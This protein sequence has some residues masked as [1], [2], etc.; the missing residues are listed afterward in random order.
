MD[1]DGEGARRRLRQERARRPHRLTAK[2]PKTST[3]APSIAAAP[4]APPVPAAAGK[5]AEAVG[6]LAA[7][8]LLAIGPG[9]IGGRALPAA[10]GVLL[11]AAAAVAVDVPIGAGVAIAVR[12]SRPVGI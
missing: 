2:A 1:D 11:P 3:A 6:P 12:R 8:L 10:G 9:G 7:R 5:A 4:A